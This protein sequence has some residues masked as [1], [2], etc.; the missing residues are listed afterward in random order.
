MYVQRGFG[1]GASQS[2]TTGRALVAMGS[3]ASAFTPVLAP[4]TNSASSA[5]M[6]SVAGQS[7][8]A[9]ILS[10]AL[11][12]LNGLTQQPC[13]PQYVVLLTDGLPT[14]D[15][16]N[17]AWPPLG[18]T[19][20]NNYG[21]TATF[22]ADGSLATTNDQALTD[23]IT[24]IANLKRSGIKTYI[25]GL[26]AGVNN[27]ANPLAAQTLQAMAIAG[28]TN[29]Y[30]A[31]NDG[32][33]LSNAFLSIVGEIYSTSTIGAPVAPPSVG[34]GNAYEYTL[35]S[36]QSPASGSAKAYA[37]AADGSAS[38]PTASWDAAALMTR[39][40]RSAALM[41]NASDGKMKLLSKMDKAAFA[42]PSSPP[43]C[44]PNMDVVVAYTVDPSYTYTPSSGTTCSY[45]AG[46]QPGWFLGTFSGQTLGKYV[47]PPA[48]T[49]LVGDASYVS[50]ARAR[51]A[52]TPMLMFTNND[53]F[54]Y[55]VNAATGAL[56]W[57]WTPRSVLAQMQNYGTFQSSQTM[58]GGFTVVD[59]KD[60]KGKWGTYVV[61]S[62]QSGA[63]HFSL[64]LDDDGMPDSVVYDGV[65][66][67]G[68][69]PGDKSGA[70]GAAPLH[71]PVQI[72][73]KAGAAYTVYVVNT[74]SGST[75]YEVNVATG[76]VSSASLGFVSSAALQ[77]DS[78]SGRIW[79][80]SSAG[81]IWNGAFTGNA[82]ADAATMTSIGRT[83]AP[84]QATTVVT[85]VLYVGY[86]EVKGVPFVY[87]VNASQITLFGV[88]A[89]GW[90]PLW[91]T[92]TASGYRY[93]SG[94]FTTSTAVTTLMTG[95][96]V[97][98]A[99]FIVGSTLLL[100]VYVPP[101]LTC[102]AGTAYYQFFGLGS[103]SLPAQTLT[104][105]G[106][107]VGASLM[108][109]SGI[110]YTPTVTGVRFGAGA[111]GVALNTGAQSRTLALS[112]MTDGIAP[113]IYPPRGTSTGP[114]AWRQ[115]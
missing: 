89:A 111:F 37:V 1:Y 9:G 74:A 90:T 13:Q 55:A 114:I 108:V 84:A 53:G 3:A 97:S 8:I 115:L 39:T 52:R 63:Q 77:L 23:T 51:A 29:S 14:L 69:A 99:P 81:A 96:I 79:L 33:A 83:V 75:L 43:P 46:R 60:D 80:G 68:S 48:S 11:S 112:G 105:K 70:T 24:A 113:P 58:N 32:D 17:K 15:L 88:G 41:S 101:T 98:D 35:T 16:S 40:K 106:A 92:T 44:V 30:Y 10:G 50:F 94:A 54:L 2:A 78:Q 47:G 38:S 62:L 103:G 5:E 72:G 57:G 36:N 93:A 85:P 6:K 110:A 104:Y 31:A 67:G 71:Q 64:Q 49:A 45:L 100:P 73:R 109:G 102:G 25:V 22:N 95:G 76:A 27:A 87:A 26:G 12:Y 59:A 4:E 28:D 19:S 66:S 107:T 42:L 61:G 56:L 21:L 34:S 20:G 91:A 65:V 86:T 18:S 7:A 82:A